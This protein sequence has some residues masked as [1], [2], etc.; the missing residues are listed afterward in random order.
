[1]KQRNNFLMEKHFADN[2]MIMTSNKSKNMRHKDIT[3]TKNIIY[4]ISGGPTG[5]EDHSVTRSKSFH[6]PRL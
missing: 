6:S 2:Q 5:I 1:M 3:R 4:C